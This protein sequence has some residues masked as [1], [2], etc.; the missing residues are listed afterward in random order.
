MSKRFWAVQIF[1]WGR[2][3]YRW[4]KNEPVDPYE[5][6]RHVAPTAGAPGYEYNAQPATTEQHFAP[7][8]EDRYPEMKAEH[9]HTA[10]YE[11]GLVEDR[12]RS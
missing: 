4:W 11:K 12:K 9:I 5:T 3:A 2:E 8:S 1:K 10:P 6:H 7:Q